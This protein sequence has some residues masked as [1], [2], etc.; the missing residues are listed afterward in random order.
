MYCQSNDYLL[1]LFS[2]GLGLNIGQSYMTMFFH[3]V[4]YCKYEIMLIT[5]IMLNVY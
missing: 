3:C 1:F 5:E 4:K 2:A